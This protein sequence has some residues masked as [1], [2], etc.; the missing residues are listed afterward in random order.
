MCAPP[1]S[2]RVVLR[3]FLCAAAFGALMWAGMVV[4]ALELFHLV[5]LILGAR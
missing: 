5:H 4:G 2:P 3:T 1:T